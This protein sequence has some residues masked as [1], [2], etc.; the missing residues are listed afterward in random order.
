MIPSASERRLCRVLRVA[1]SWA[2]HRPTAWAQP[3]SINRELATRVAELIRGYPTFGYRRLWALLRF[4]DGHRVTRRTV[5]RLCERQG[6]FVHQRTATPRPRVHGRRSR[7]AHSN[8]RWATDVTHVPCG[9]DGWAH[10]AAVIDCHDREVIGYEFALRGRA[11]E[12]ERALEEA[13]LAR[14]GT[15]RPSG[16][17][18]TVRSDN[19][20]IYQSRR[21]RGACRDYRLRQ[22]FITPYTPEQNGLIERFFRSLKEECVWQHN[23]PDFTAARRAIGTWI[24]WYNE[25]RPHQALGYQSPQQFRAHEAGAVA[26]SGSTIDLGGAT[27]VSP[28]ESACVLQQLNPVA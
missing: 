14:F 6:W 2:R 10:L 27:S 20:L 21:F 28:S 11:R 8:E 26:A 13:C 19:G 3:S 16:P 12:A 9:R 22:E 24:R 1:R 17:T 23:F 25:G 15:L 5:Y 4:R 18:P 7:A